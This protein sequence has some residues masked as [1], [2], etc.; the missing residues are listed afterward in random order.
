MHHII[1]VVVEGKMVTLNVGASVNGNA[2]RLKQKWIVW[3][4]DVIRKYTTPRKDV[5]DHGLGTDCIAKGF[6]VDIKEFKD[7]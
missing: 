3:I 6:N 2:I 4:E 1:T 5:V 7:I